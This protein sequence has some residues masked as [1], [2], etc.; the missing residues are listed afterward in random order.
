MNGAII[1]FIGNITRDP[2]ELKYSKNGGTA[3]LTIGVAVNTW[4]GPDLPVLTDYYDATLFGRN[5]ENALNRCRKGHQVFVQGN[6]RMRGYNRQD[7]TQAIAHD[8]S[9]REL[10]HFH[11]D[12]RPQQ[13]DAGTAQIG[14]GQ[15][16]SA[17]S[18]AGGETQASQAQNQQAHENDELMDFSE[19]FIMEP[20]EVGDPFGEETAAGG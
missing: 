10:H 11:R 12:P 20:V 9:V 7:G 5:A 18:Q 15:A 17:G 2:G 14:A 4:Q 13:D 19:P 16:H 3:Y 6:Y 1:S 8:V